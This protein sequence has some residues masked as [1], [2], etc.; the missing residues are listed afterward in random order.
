MRH[1]LL[2]DISEP[3]NISPLWASS[4]MEWTQDFTPW[5]AVP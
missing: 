3:G 1:Y 4:I 5:E 2:P